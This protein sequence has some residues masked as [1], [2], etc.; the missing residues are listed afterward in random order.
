MLVRKTTGHVA[1]SVHHDQMT[2]SVATDL[3]LYYI[4]RHICLNSYG[5][6][7]NHITIHKGRKSDSSTHLCLV[8]S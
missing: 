8:D 3:G 4:L 7:D 1:K 2:N 6:Y 5:K